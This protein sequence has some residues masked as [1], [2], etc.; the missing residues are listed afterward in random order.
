MGGMVVGA[1]IGTP[2]WYVKTAD[3]IVG[4]STLLDDESN[5]MI[6]DH[7]YL[8][9]QDGMVE[10][11]IT[12]AVPAPLIVVGY[13]DTDSNPADGG[14]VRVYYSTTAYIENLHE[15]S[16]TFLMSKG[17]YFEITATGATVIIRWIPFAALVA[18]TD[19]N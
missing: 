9:N 5:A 7:A 16:L 4:L 17:R 18:C 11:I 19:N 14:D 2:T 6:K 3:H 1:F 15:N 12:H 10:L 8:C 13:D